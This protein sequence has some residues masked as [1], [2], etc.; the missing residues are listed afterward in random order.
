MINKT[1][2]LNSLSIAN[3]SAIYLRWVFNTTGSNSQ[4]LGLDNVSLTATAASAT[5]PTITSFTPA[6]GQ[7]G[8]SVTI[9][10]TNFAS[11]ATVSF[12]GT[13]STSVTFTNNTSLN[14][15]VPAG[16]TSGPITVTVGAE[17]GVSSTS[18]TVVNP[19]APA[20]STN[21]TL[22]AFSTTFGNASAAQT[23]GVTGTNLTA[24]IAATVPTGFEVSTDG[25]TYG[26]NATIT[27]SSGNASATLSVR[28]AS[29]A[30]VGALTGNLTLASTGATSVA[31]PL[32]GNVTANLTPGIVV[33]SQAYGGGGNSGAPY[34]NDFVELFNPG[35]S[36]I[37]L[38]GWTIQWASATGTFGGT[39]STA[40]LSGSIA[41]K[42]YYLIQLAAGANASAAALPTPDAT[43][44]I[45]LGA[46]SF[47]IALVN[48]TTALSGTNPLGNPSIIDFVG[49]GSTTN[50]F[51]GAGPAPAPS[52]TTAILR[53]LGGEQD[54]ND[55]A[56]DFETGAPNPRN[57]GGAPA[58]PSITSATS[59]N[60]TVG[61]AFSYTIT[62]SNSPAS[63]GATGLPA[64]LTVNTT[65]GLISGTPTTA[66][67]S[68]ATISA[69][70]LGGTG[71]ATLSFTIAQGTPVITTPPT[72]SAI[73]AGQ[74]L[75]AS[76]LTGGLA[77]VPGN[78][79]FATPSFVP[80]ATG[81]QLVLF[82]PDDSA[83][84]T[85]ANT[86]VTVT[87]NSGGGSPFDT[88]AGGNVTMTPAV[89]SLYAIGGGSYNGTVA[90]EAP[91]L[92][93]TGGNLS[94]TAIVRT[95][96]PAL[97]VTGESVASLDGIWTSLGNGTVSGNQTGV[98]PGLQR[99]EFST[100]MDG[101]KKFLRLRAVYTGDN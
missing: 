58:A 96:D 32:S 98:G 29:S 51:E 42:G 59:A 3:G 20:I 57:S 33:I 19:N 80:G 83:N 9:T 71:N 11:N 90:P 23:V 5:A 47:K 89:L 40:T 41:S 44:N 100:P 61:T 70:N 85:T 65:T 60:A 25:T 92:S 10:G 48:S 12:N 49:A 88:W 74:A 21:G 94:L 17:S 39:N 37:S 56:A 14:A 79:T 75:S 50:A 46:T 7:V 73:T 63:F 82:T 99:R 93:T 87:V 30:S 34:R 4:G 69:T 26:P 15:T 64:G 6:S 8:D 81:S 97:T 43:G 45:N 18:F 78:F 13:S 95:D 2:S 66:G 22:T 62:A 31:I 35:N 1:V 54:T 24:D 38:D 68:N 28:I 55:N 67:N 86:S 36:S 91:V 84:Y 52:N 27:Q 72:A 53:K 77:S 76:T 101:T 16:A